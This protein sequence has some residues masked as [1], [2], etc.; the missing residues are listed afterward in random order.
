[1]KR[2]LKWGGVAVGSLIG[3]LLIAGG[4][5]HMVGSSRL[6]HAPDVPVKVVPVPTDEAAI[7]RGEHLATVSS[8]AGCHGQGLRGDVFMDEPPFGLI[9]AP[10]LTSGQGGIGALLTDGD[11]E[12]AIRHGVG[13]DGR[14]LMFMPSYHYYTYSDE[15]LGALISYLESLPPADNGPGSRHIT[16]PGTIIAGML[17]YDDLTSINRIDHA[18]VGGSEPAMGETAAYGAY[19]VNVASCGSCHGENLAGNYDPSAGPTGPNLTPSGEL[20]SWSRDDFFT[21]MRTGST[22]AGRQLSEIMPWR[23]FSHMTDEELG[24]IWL[25]LQ[26]LDV[27]LASQP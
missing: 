22:P 3:L 26:S 6:S 8:C 11:W 2:I 13:H 14:A 25:Y 17:A 4:I 9:P 19:L 21:A 27:T 10:N 5:L 12:R 15:D 23:G 1:M 18:Q 16:F 24:A 20:Q 7:A